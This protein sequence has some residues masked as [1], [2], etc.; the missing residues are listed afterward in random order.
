M[1]PSLP[2]I[3]RKH[4]LNANLVFRPKFGITLNRNLNYVNNSVKCDFIKAIDKVT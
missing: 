3:L 2:S 4:D 1:E